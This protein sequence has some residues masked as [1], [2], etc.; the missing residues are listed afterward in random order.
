VRA[1]AIC[2]SCVRVSERLFLTV[3]SNGEG[4]CEVIYSLA[5][6]CVGLEVGVRL[7]DG[8]RADG[9]MPNSFSIVFC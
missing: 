5:S 6:V 3:F 2:P 7:G 4:R 9:K 8:Y 1:G